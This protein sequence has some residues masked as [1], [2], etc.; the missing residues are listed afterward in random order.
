MSRRT[1]A[2]ELILDEK[3]IKLRRQGLTQDAICAELGLSKGKVN[4]VCQGLKTEEQK[5]QR[6]VKE[7]AEKIANGEIKVDEPKP[8]RVIKKTPT[9]DIPIPKGSDLIDALK[10]GAFEKELKESFEACFH[11]DESTKKYV[12]VDAITTLEKQGEK[13]VETKKT[14]YQDPAKTFKMMEN[15]IKLRSEINPEMQKTDMQLNLVIGNEGD[16]E[17][18]LKAFEDSGLDDLDASVYDGE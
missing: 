1:K 12:L 15:Y 8:K 2:D 18:Y 6:Q 3:I 13:W 14:I 17:K 7:I 11:F 4:K 5:K 16:M 10:A 9:P